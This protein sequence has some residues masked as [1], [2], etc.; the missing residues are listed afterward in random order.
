MDMAA[1][2]PDGPIPLRLFWPSEETGLPV[3]VWYHG[4]GWVAGTLDQIDP[5]ARRLCNAAQCI[6][7]AVDYRLAPEHPYPAGRDDAYAALVWA[8]Q[9]ARR[10]GGDAE[11]IAVGGDSAGGNLAAVV[12]QMARDRAGLQLRQ[13]VLIY[14]VTDL[15]RGAP[16]HTSNGQGYLLTRGA[17]EMFTNLYLPDLA[18]RTAPRASPLRAASHSNLPPAIVQTAEFDPLRD[19]GAAYAQKLISSG[20]TTD[21]VCY[22]GMIHGFARMGSKVDDGKR[23]LEDAARKLRELLA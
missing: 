8:Y 20:V 17:M 18:S 16:S 5:T 6:V 23:A 9:N 10:F 4:G 1:A 19:E 21:Y 15:R 12:A 2:G 22:P 3:L 11:R 14:P 13:Q 7:I